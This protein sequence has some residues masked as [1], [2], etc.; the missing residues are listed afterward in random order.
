MRIWKFVEDKAT[1][2]LMVEDVFALAEL[3]DVALHLSASDYDRLSH[4][5]DGFDYVCMIR[6]NDRLVLFPIWDVYCYKKALFQHWVQQAHERNL[7]FYSL[8]GK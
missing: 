6:Q 8:L 4:L 5:M 1:D 2:I 3:E 7:I